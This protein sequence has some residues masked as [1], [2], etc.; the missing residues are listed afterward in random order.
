MNN[1]HVKIIY[2]S[3]KVFIVCVIFFTIIL[4]YL[5]QITASLSVP[6]VTTFDLIIEVLPVSSVIS[7]IIFCIALIYGYTREYNKLIK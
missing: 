7:I 2:K 5:N 6:T 4:Y 1:L 3:L